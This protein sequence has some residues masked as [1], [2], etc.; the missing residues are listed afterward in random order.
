MRVIRIPLLVLLNLVVVPGSNGEDSPPFRLAGYLPDYRAA[1][2]DPVAARSLTDLIVFSGEPTS[3]GELDLSRLKK[4]PWAKLRSFKTRERIR[5]MLCVGGWGRSTHFATVSTTDSKRA[6][7]VEAV[8]RFCLNERFDGIDLDWEHPKNA[9]EQEGYAKL[10]ADLRTAFEP[11]GLTL[12]VTVAGWQKLPAKAFEVVD[13]VNVMAYDHSGKHSTFEGAKADVE[14]LM[15]AGAPARKITLG[16]PFYGRDTAQRE[17]AMA[18]RDIVA[19]HKP[20]PELDEVGT[21]YF[22]GPAMVKRKTEYAIEAHLA[23]VMVW[24]L[25]QDAPGE[26]SLLKVIRSVAGKLTRE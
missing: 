18:Y 19:K 11:H 20:E 8:T 17:R 21:L 15:A 10:L 1:S 7:F 16:L 13:W 2:F 12:S 4:I 5:L 23:G 24:E 6:K 22:N 9:E 14:K 25:G 26:Q 3:S